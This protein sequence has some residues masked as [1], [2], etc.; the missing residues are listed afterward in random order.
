MQHPHHCVVMVGG[1]LGGEQC[2]ASNSYLVNVDIDECASDPGICGV[3]EVCINT[4]G[5]YECP[6]APGFARSENGTA[7]ECMVGVCSM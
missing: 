2:W 4:D 7:C 5:G 1:E 3:N 6:C